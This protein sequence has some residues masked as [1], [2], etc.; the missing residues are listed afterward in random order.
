[1]STQIFI[2]STNNKNAVRLTELLSNLESQE[3]ENELRKLGS[4]C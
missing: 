3:V 2:R 1:M 4:L